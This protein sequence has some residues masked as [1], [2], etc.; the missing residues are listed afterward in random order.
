MTSDRRIVFVMEHHAIRRS[1]TDDHSCRPAARSTPFTRPCGSARSADS[2]ESPSATA[3]GPSSPGWPHWSSPCCSRMTMGGDF[4]AD[5]S[6]P[7][8][9]SKEAQTLLEDRFPSQAGDTVD[10]VVR[11][12]GGVQGQQ[13]AVRGP[14]RRPRLGRSRRGGLRPLRGP[15]RHQPGRHD[16]GGTPAPRRGEPRRHAARGQRADARD[17]RRRLERPASRSA[18]GGQSIVQAEQGEIGS[19]GL[20]LAAAA[21]ILLIMFGSRRRGRTPHHHG[22]RRARGEQHADHRR[23]LL[24]RRARL[25]DLAGHDDGHRHRHRL[26]AAHGHPLPRVAGRRPRPR[27]RHGGHPRHRRPLGD[28]RGHHGGDQHARPVRHGPVVHARRGRGDHPRRAG[29]DGSP[30]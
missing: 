24:R 11:A 19:E 9:D 12:D 17:R 30:A 13:Q 23:H 18:S 10:V 22:C 27:G 20:G 1:I 2:P 6:A 21:I 4:K 5:Y 26:R 3:D 28:G 25:V 16:A 8:S 7:G 15:G 29:R 14:A